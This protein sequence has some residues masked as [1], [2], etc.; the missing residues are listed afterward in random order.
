MRLLSPVPGQGV[1]WAGWPV[2]V[3]SD[4][5]ARAI[6]SLA[7]KTDTALPSKT[8]H[9]S[10]ENRREGSHVDSQ[11]CSLQPSRHVSSHHC[12]WA[13]RPPHVSC[14]SLDSPHLLTWPACVSSSTL[15]DHPCPLP[16]R[17]PPMSPDRL[18]DRQHTGS[19]HAEFPPRPRAP[20]LAPHG[21]LRSHLSCRLSCPRCNTHAGGAQARG[22]TDTL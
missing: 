16:S 21:P 11:S 19:G 4:S 20:H 2:L 5:T 9:Q 1:C 22:V 8:F 18:C 15:C 10:E 17:P 12:S 14:L 6:L 3:Q 13:L 7:G